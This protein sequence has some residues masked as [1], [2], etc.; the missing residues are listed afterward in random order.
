[1]SDDTNR[2]VTPGTFREVALRLYN[3][4]EIFEGATEGGF[5]FSGFRETFVG[6]HE[7]N[8]GYV[9]AR[10]T[11]SAETIGQHD[12]KLK[13]QQNEYV[14]AKLRRIEFSE[15]PTA[16]VM[17][18]VSDVFSDGELIDTGYINGYRVTPLSDVI[19]D[20]FKWYGQGDGR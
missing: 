11:K 15:D 19:E 6:Y 14:R 13:T 8:G 9:V 2:M 7:G 3:G 4:K 17:D 1:M 18:T 5:V 10:M 16:I 12:A 20:V